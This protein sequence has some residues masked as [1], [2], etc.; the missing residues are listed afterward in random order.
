MQHETFKYLRKIR[1]WHAYYIFYILIH[2]LYFNL[3]LTQLSDSV[4][5]FQI[6]FSLFGGNLF[7]SIKA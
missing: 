7:S 5:L 4:Y 3:K 2:P 1:M 6:V